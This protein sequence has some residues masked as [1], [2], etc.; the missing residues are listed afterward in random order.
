M[1]KIKDDIQLAIDDLNT[2]L[3]ICASCRL[4]AKSEPS[5]AC[6]IGYAFYGRL[7]QALA[8]EEAVR[9]LNPHLIIA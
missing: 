3:E 6:Q 9:E 2:H 5:Y 7:E 4:G 1:L 8:L